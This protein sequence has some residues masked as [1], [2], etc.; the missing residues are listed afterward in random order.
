MTRI[1]SDSKPA[2]VLII[3]KRPSKIATENLMDG[4][5]FGRFD[6]NDLSVEPAQVCDIWGNKH[7]ST[8]I[9][10]F[11][12]NSLFIAEIDAVLRRVL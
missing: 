10:N 3:L 5:A 4:P 2:T 9:L 11:Y 1:V 6:F 12:E 8:R 7:C